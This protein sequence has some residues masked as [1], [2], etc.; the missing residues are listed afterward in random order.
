[1]AGVASCNPSF[2]LCPSWLLVTYSLLVLVHP[3]S[4]SC[5][6]PIA[7]S[8]PICPLTSS[9]RCL[10]HTPGH[11]NNTSHLPQGALLWANPNCWTEQNHTEL[12]TFY[13][14]NPD[15]VK[16][17]ETI[18]EQFCHR[19]CHWY[20]FSECHHA[21][22]GGSRAV[23]I[24]DIQS[25]LVVLLLGWLNDLGTQFSLQMQQ[26]PK[27]ALMSPAAE[28]NPLNQQTSLFIIHI[29]VHFFHQLFANA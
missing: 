1:M 29:I 18:R 8:T 19:Y 6:L 12:S 26:V 11:G 21:E 22:R 17:G 3:C 23:P 13:L 2:P 4:S 20:F 10:G 5:W 9:L 25:K 27:D 15:L 24:H 28:Q 16:W 7:L 14:L